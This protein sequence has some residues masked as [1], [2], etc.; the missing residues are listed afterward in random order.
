MVAVAALILGRFAIADDLMR[1]EVTIRDHRFWPSDIHVP[2]GNPT[3]LVII[4]TDPTA[5]EFDSLA[6]KVEKLVPGGGS[7]TIRL[8]PLGA[9]RYPF[10]GEFHADTAK[11]AVISE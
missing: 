2:A 7:V 10:A 1:I 9:G 11:G 3:A 5:E 6:L 8:R 4:N